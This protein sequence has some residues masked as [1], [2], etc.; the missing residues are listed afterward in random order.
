MSA[1]GSA[2]YNS[3]CSRSKSSSLGSSGL[4]NDLPLGRPAGQ[5]GCQPRCIL[6]CE[7]RAASL[8][9]QHPAG[10]RQGNHRE[11]RRRRTDRRGV[12][13]EGTTPV[14]CSAGVV[15]A[16]DPAT[17]GI[18][19]TAVGT[20]AAG[21]L[22]RMGRVQPG[23]TL[24]H[25]PRLRRGCGTPTP[26]GTKP[27]LVWTR[28]HRD[29]ELRNVNTVQPQHVRAE[30]L[31]QIPRRLLPSP[32]PVFRTDEILGRRQLLPAGIAPDQSAGL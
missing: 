14:T 17:H 12:T 23:A 7:D 3:S 30:R 15:F 27:V 13:V 11:L 16:S 18:F 21:G 29:D 6:R 22:P 9:V 20:I 31:R 2:G 26:P 28:G 4:R 8:P 24:R 32:P 1:P 25:H 5:V 10:R 19:E